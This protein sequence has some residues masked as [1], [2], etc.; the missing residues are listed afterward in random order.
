MV[1]TV[2]KIKIKVLKYTFLSRK[3]LYDLLRLRDFRFIAIYQREDGRASSLILVFTRTRRPIKR[4]ADPYK[5]V[6]S[7][8]ECSI[9][10]LNARAINLDGLLHT[11]M[12][13]SAIFKGHANY[14]CHH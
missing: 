13:T 2:S 8:G 12:H 3:K 14:I 4:Y 1:L 9:N 10:R 11:F 5:K 7:E 6:F